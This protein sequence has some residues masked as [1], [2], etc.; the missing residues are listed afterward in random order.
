MTGNGILWRNKLVPLNC[1]STVRERPLQVI[2]HNLIKS[3][4]IGYARKASGRL[5]DQQDQLPEARRKPHVLLEDSPRGKWR[6]CAHM[7]F[8]T[9]AALGSALILNDMPGRSATNDFT[10][11]QGSLLNNGMLEEVQ[12]HGRKERLDRNS[13]IIMVVC[14]ST[15]FL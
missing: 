15:V 2:L 12:G 4:K 3:D 14:R 6:S 11:V 1:A 10:V 9:E 8:R 5:R 7:A 13:R